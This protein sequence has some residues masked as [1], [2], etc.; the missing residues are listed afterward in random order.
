MDKKIFLKWLK[1]NSLCFIG[2][3]AAVFILTQ[4]VPNIMLGLMKGWWSLIAM[5]GGK[6]MEEF[7]SMFDAFI[8]IVFRN[9]ISVSV[10]FIIGLLLYAPLLMIIMGSFYS[11]VAFAVPLT[12]GDPQPTGF[13]ILA[14]I[15]ALFLIISAS[16]AS[17]LGTEIY[18]IKPEKKQLSGYWK[19][20]TI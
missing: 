13:W 6:R 20:D 9:S 18:G 5:A 3:F 15:E 17:T 11:L 16:F 1:I 7:P 14:I 2:A 12:T 10:A 4:L 8:Y 19:K